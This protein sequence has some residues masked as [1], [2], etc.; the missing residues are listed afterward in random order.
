MSDTPVMKYYP[1]ILTG[2]SETAQEQLDRLQDAELQELGVVAAQLDVIDGHFADAVTLSPLDLT[3]LDF[4]GMQIDLHLMVDEPLDFLYEAISVK[5]QLPIRA[6]IAQIEHMSYQAPFVE[7]VKKQGWKVGLSLDLHTPVE[8]IEEAS[9]Q[10]LD[11]VQIMGNYAGKQGQHFNPIALETIKEV[12]AEVKVRGLNC[13]VLV[14]IG[15]NPTT[16]QLMKKAGAT[17]TCPGSLLW[18]SESI[19]DT[20]HQLN[21]S[22]S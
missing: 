12:A 3:E 11:V 8:E 14:D 5:D 21:S 7:E 10:H 20:L 2:S 17:G 19:V 1:S 18:K 15:V 9:W 16:I 13:E 4:H 6:V 22:I